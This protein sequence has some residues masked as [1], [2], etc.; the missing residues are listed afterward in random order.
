M[1]R[2]EKKYNQAT[3]NVASKKERN[4]SYYP[5]KLERIIHNISYGLLRLG[6]EGTTKLHDGMMTG[7][8]SA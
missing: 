7:I 6:Y 5:H 4:Y 3:I 2:I 8:S 1:T